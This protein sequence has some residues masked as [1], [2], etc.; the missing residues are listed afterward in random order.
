MD[1]NFNPNRTMDGSSI[2]GGSGKQA[3]DIN[4]SSS[5][6]DQ[7]TRDAGARA[8]VNGS[9]IAVLGGLED[10][11]VAVVGD[12]VAIRAGPET[13]HPIKA[14]K[15]RFGRD[16]YFC[17]MLLWWTCLNN[18]NLPLGLFETSHSSTDSTSLYYYTEYE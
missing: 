17:M 4:T 7:N 18:L 10:G 3:F 13:Y 11:Q 9:L 8:D 5:S 2:L 1:E 16:I 12:L 14:L 6:F 15:V